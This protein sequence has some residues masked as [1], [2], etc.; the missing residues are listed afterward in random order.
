MRSKIDRL[1]HA[2]F[3]EIIGICLSAP[4][5]AAGFQTDLLK[6][7]IIGGVISLLAM[8]WNMVYNYCFDLLLVRCGHPLNRRTLM[9]RTAHALFFEAGLAMLTIP[10]VAWWLSIPLLKALLLDFSLVCFYLVYALVYNWAYDRLFPYPAWEAS[11][12]K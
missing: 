7:G 4:L 2:L 10:M 12:I 6:T 9:L 8:L 5:V 11:L 1:R 3:F